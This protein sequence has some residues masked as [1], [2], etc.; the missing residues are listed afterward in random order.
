M[1]I[2]KIATAIAVVGVM[3]LS[4]RAAARRTVNH[5]AEKLTLVSSQLVAS[6]QMAIQMSPIINDQNMMNMNDDSCSPQ[7]DLSSMLHSPE[8]PIRK[9]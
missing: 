3:A 6:K 4:F 2:L 7:D 5:A 9:M 1:S 8:A